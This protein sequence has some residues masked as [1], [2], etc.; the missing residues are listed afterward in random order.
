MVSG[1]FHAVLQLY[2][3]QSY[4]R[5]ESGV[6]GRGLSFGDQLL[7][8]LFMQQAEEQRSLCDWHL[9]FTLIYRARRLSTR[10]PGPASSVETFHPHLYNYTRICGI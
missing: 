2:H 5:L 8:R 7:Q 9:L 4:L 10:N 6:G 3:A 1:V